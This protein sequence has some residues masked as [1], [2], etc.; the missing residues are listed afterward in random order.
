MRAERAKIIIAHSA[1]EISRAQ[2]MRLGF[3]HARGRECR[4]MKMLKKLSTWLAGTTGKKH[5]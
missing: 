3:L 4:K 2:F 1:V 5:S